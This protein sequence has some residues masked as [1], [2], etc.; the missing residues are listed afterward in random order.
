MNDINLT[1]VDNQNTIHTIEDVNEQHRKRF[2]I[3]LKK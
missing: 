1:K 2:E 3:Y